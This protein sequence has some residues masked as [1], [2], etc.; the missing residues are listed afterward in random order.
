MYRSTH[1]RSRGS[2]RARASNVLSVNLG[3]RQTQPIPA[4]SKTDYHSTQPTVVESG[5]EIRAG[6]AR[7]KNGT[8]QFSLRYYKL[9][10]RKV[11]RRRTVRR[12]VARRGERGFSKR[13]KQR[14]PPAGELIETWGSAKER[15]K[16]LLRARVLPSSNFS[17]RIQGNLDLSQRQRIRHHTA[18][19]THSLSP[20]KG[21]P[22]AIHVKHKHTPAHAQ[23]SR[24]TR[25]ERRV[26][27]PLAASRRGAHTPELVTAETVGCERTPPF[28]KKIPKRKNLEKKNM[29]S[30]GW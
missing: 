16:L 5:D 23:S 19:H 2:S 6:R 15:D 21:Q 22:L 18:P 28:S 11:S 9:F 29:F 25:A 24:E 8:V 13:G 14:R 4:A 3:P 7:P 17:F 26:V 20:T 30:A 1:T 12:D 27:L 10:V